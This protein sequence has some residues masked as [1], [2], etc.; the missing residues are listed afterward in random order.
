MIDPAPQLDRLNVLFRKV[1]AVLG[2]PLRS[3]SR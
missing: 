3:Q 1:E 2:V